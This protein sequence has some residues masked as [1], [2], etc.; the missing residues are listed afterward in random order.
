MGEHF[1]IVGNGAAGFRAAKALRQADAAA[2]IS[3]FTRE[4]YPFYV[5][6][7]LG[8]FLSGETALGELIFQG[9]NAYRRERLDLFLM[10]RIEQV[11]PASHEVVLASG[12]RVRYDRLLVATG[13]EAVPLEV[14]GADLGGVLSFD[15][16]GPALEARTALKEG[17]LRRAVLLGCGLTNLVLA[18]G[19][20]KRGI[21]VTQVM[22][23]DRYWPEMLDEQA[24]D[25]V[26]TLLEQH[27]VAI[28]RS[29]AARAVVGAG[30]QAVG[31]ECTD[32]TVLAADLVGFGSDRRPAVGLLKGS[33]VEIGRGVRVGARCQ[34]SH[35][36][37]FAAGD[38]TEPGFATAQP[39]FALA[40][41]GGGSDGAGRPFCWQR[42]WTQGDLAAAGMLDRAADPGADAV[43]MRT[44]VFGRDL[45]VIGCGH[46]AEAGDVEALQ[47]HA[48][49]D[50][51]RRLVFR[52]GRLVG[53]IVFG[54]GESVPE[55]NRFVAA[56]ETRAAVEAALHG[57]RPDRAMD[58]LPQTFAQHCPICAAELVVHRGTPMGQTFRCH[59]CNTD[60][61]VRWDG[62]RGGLEVLRP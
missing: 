45:A 61:A 26:E 44:S 7:Q 29:A 56:R 12:D 58:T 52:G 20:A 19:L 28:R 9:R 51:Y 1:V 15:G 18:E 54:T 47:V 22:E 37:V 8:R 2:R 25:L 30:G 36:D 38:V 50:T 31:V 60:L 46:L 23:S 32:G 49:A 62:A 24:S 43:R 39:A 14:P 53:A 4:R 10:T 59:V 41:P 40:E 11:V 21:R 17:R 5:R 35:T 6:R 42:A 27:G 13:T 3:I 55:L 16:L 34:T 33:G 57:P 48:P